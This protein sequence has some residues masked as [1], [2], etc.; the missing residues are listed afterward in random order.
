MLAYVMQAVQGCAC[1]QDTS[2]KCESLLL[3]RYQQAE[4]VHS[5]WAMIAVAGILFPEVSMCT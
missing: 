5:R 1:C 4:L 3:N 2:G